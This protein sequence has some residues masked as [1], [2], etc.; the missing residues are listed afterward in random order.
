VAIIG[1]MGIVVIG[2]LIYRR[3]H[4]PTTREVVKVEM[5]QVP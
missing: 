1:T 5:I 4:K 3:W 2:V